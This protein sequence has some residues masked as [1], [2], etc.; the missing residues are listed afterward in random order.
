[1]DQRALFDQVSQLEAALPAYREN[2]P[3]LGI[4]GNIK[5]ILAVQPEIF[6]Y[7]VDFIGGNALVGSATP[8]PINLF[9]NIQQDAAFKILGATYFA[10]IANAAQT[11]STRVIPLTTIL[12]TD[13]GNGR[14]FSNAAVPITA[15][16]GHQGLPMYWP[17]PKTVQS[18]ASIQVQATPFVAAGTTYNLRFYFCGTKLYKYTAQA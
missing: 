15:L 5:S 6:W 7:G 11:D 12:L 14:N 8:T 2:Q 10:D 18:L 13:T 1:M 4:I 16:A 9:V 3:A 17:E